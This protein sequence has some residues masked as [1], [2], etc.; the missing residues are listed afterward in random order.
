MI[1]RLS[2]FCFVLFASVIASCDKEDAAPNVVGTWKA[3]SSESYNC[4]QASEN[5]ILTCGTYAWC[6]DFT[7]RTDKTFEMRYIGSSINFVYSSGTYRVMKGWLFLKHVNDPSET[8]Y[9]LTVS[10]NTLITEL[11][12]DTSDCDTRDTFQK[13]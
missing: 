8:Q 4:D 1:N 12:T 11:S 9:K 2:F 3:V 7:L 10:G 6:V 5:K 13:I